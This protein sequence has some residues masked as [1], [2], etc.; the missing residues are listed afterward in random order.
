MTFNELISKIGTD[1]VLHFS[2]GGFIVALLTIVVTL[3]EGIIDA[4]AIAFP[5]IGL[6]A[7]AIF[8]WF[9]EAVIDEEFSWT[10]ILASVLGSVPVFIAQALGV[11]FYILSN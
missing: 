8:S 4:T 3:Q 2:V 11:L 6:I 9:K 7:V 5:F 10:D 1:K